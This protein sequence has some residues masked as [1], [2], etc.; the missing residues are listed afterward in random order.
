MRE[1]SW[2]PCA[3]TKPYVIEPNVAEAFAAWNEVEFS[4]NLGVQNIILEGDA[5]ERGHVFQKEGQSCLRFG[6]LI[7]GSKKILHSL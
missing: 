6:N 4:K 3:R 7:D 5:L 1:R 2:K